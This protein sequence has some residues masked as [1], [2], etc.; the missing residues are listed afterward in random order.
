MP[1]IRHVACI[2][3]EPTLTVPVFLA[4]FSGP[5]ADHSMVSSTST[6][7]SLGM[8]AAPTH[9]QMSVSA[10][11][12][13]ISRTRALQCCKQGHVQTPRLALTVAHVKAAMHAHA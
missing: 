7:N 2:V 12:A 8:I 1:Q 11:H 6:T 13:T 10:L 9:S 5:Q 4:R 3:L